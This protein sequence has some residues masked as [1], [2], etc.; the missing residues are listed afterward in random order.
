MTSRNLPDNE[1]EQQIAAIWAE[2]LSLKPHQV[3]RDISFIE[4]GGNSLIATRI[5]SRLRS[6]LDISL[7]LMEIVMTSDTVAAQAVHVLKHRESASAETG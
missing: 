6:D 7:S 3:A 1:I 5:A 4:I 2:L